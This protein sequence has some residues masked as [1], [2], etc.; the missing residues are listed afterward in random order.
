MDGNRDVRTDRTRLDGLSAGIA[1]RPLARAPAPPLSC[2][3]HTDRSLPCI[4]CD[5]CSISAATVA[6]RL[7]RTRTIKITNR[8][9]PN[10]ENG[11]LEKGC[12]TTRGGTVVAQPEKGVAE[13]AVAGL[14][15]AGLRAGRGRRTVQTASGATLWIRE[16]GKRIQG[17]T[18]PM[19]KCNPR[20]VSGRGDYPPPTSPYAVTTARTS[21][22]RL[23]TSAA[24]ST[25]IFS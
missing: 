25:P 21:A 12:A 19:T 3:R 7:G 9:R 13:S 16:G 22:T 20:T 10:A 8:F 6:E 18:R 14:V 15:V 23:A 11:C 5:I 2:P 24:D 4:R 17:G 1:L